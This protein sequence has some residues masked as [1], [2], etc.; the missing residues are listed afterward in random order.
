MGTALYSGMRVS[1]LLGLTWAE[2]EFDAGLFR[3]DIRDRMKA[4]AFGHL[5][6]STAPS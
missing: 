2:V 4:S 6:T 1:E 5:L 3:A